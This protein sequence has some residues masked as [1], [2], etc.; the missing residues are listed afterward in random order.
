MQDKTE[1]K[2]YYLNINALNAGLIW[3]NECFH[4]LKSLFFHYGVMLE[5]IGINAYADIFV[6]WFKAVYVFVLLCPC[7]GMHSNFSL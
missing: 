2:I 7:D 1:H 6:H 3:S 5:P 4:L